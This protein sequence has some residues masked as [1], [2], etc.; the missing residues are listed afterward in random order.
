M[1]CTVSSV[2]GYKLMI[3][4]LVTKFLDSNKDPKFVT[5]FK[6]VGHWT[7]TRSR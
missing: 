6:T 2:L 3:V 4:Q 5:A 1:Q 7:L